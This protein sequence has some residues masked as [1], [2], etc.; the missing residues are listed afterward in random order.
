MESKLTLQRVDELW[1]DGSDDWC[2]YGLRGLL[3]RSAM[4]K[5]IR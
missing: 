5:Y 3:K 2:F 1:S 4:D